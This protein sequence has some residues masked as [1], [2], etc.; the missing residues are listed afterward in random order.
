MRTPVIVLALLLPVFAEGQDVVV[1]AK[2]GLMQV[3]NESY[4][5]VYGSTTPTVGAAARLELGRRWSL[6][7][8]A[9]IGGKDGQQ[10]IYTPEGPVPGD[11]P[12]DIT[13]QTVILAVGVRAGPVVLSIGPALLRLQEE[14]EFDQESISAYGGHAAARVERS[15]GSWLGGVELGYLLVPG[16]F[17]AGGAAAVED[18]TSFSA[19]TVSASVGY[20][21]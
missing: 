1:T 8:G 5:L 7:L 18:E 11:T 4:D 17:E 13:L 14:G 2:A 3:L 12:V 9:D 20:R 15:F 10:I 16:V 19:V 6:S 21:F